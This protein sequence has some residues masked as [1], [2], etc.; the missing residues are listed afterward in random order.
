VG[1]AKERRE[2]KVEVRDGVRMDRREGGGM[3]EEGRIR[4][5]WEKLAKSGDLY[6]RL[7]LATTVVVL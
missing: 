7:V 6:V 3:E 5:K 4:E 1:T 2:R